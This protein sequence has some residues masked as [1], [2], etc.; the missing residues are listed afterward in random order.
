M[1]VVERSA[2]TYEPADRFVPSAAPVLLGGVP[3]IARLLVEQL[4]RD[5]AAGLRTGVFASGYPGSPLGGVDLALASA[6]GLADRPEFAL[7]PGVN[8]ELAATAVW[9]SQLPLPGRAST[10]DGTVGV[11]Y[12]KAPGVDRS[13][14][15]FRGANLFGANP[16]GGVLVLAGDDPGAK[17]STIPSASEATLASFGLPVLAPRSSE[18]IVRL[19]LLGIALSRVSGCWISLKIVTDVADGAWSVA[20][21]FR[22]LEIAIPELEW[23]GRPWTYRQQTVPGPPVAAVAE[24]ELVGPRWEMVQAFARANRLDEV[25]IDARDAWLGIVAPGKTSNDVL[26]AL[27]DLGLDAETA[28]RRGI[29]L[30]RIG[31][32]NPLERETV[33]DFARGVETVLV[34]EEKQPFL[35]TQVRDALY[36]SGA[37][38]VLGKR[39]LEGRP[40]VPADGE[41]TA[42][43]LADVLRRVLAARVELRPATAPPALT[44]PV[45]PVRRTAYFCSGCPHNRSTVVPEGSLAGGGIGCHGLAGMM[46]R[47]T[48]AV[49][50]L[51]HMG[52]EGAQWIGQS[53]THAGGH[54]FQNVGDGTFFHSGQLAVQAC[55]AAGVDV[56][57]KLLY[58]STVAMTGGQDAAG[59]RSVADV[60]R[61]LEAEG[62]VR[63]IVCA[64]E[65][66]RYRDLDGRLARNAVVWSRDRLD[67]AQLELRE[68]QGVTA[69]IY[70]QQCTN[71]ARRLRK[72]GQLP[73]RTTRVLINEDICEGCG[74]CSRKSNCLSVQP[75]ETELGTK[76]RIDQTSCNTDYSCL[77]GDCPSFVTVEAGPAERPAPVPAPAPPAVPDP[78]PAERAG[79]INVFFAGIGGTGVVTVNQVLATAALLDDLHVRTLDQTGMSQKAGP[80][81]SHL[82]IGRGMVEPANR[83][84]VGQADC[85]LALDLL[86]ASEA[87][88]LSYAS[89]ERTAAFVSTSEVPTGAMVD[90]YSGGTLPPHGLLLDRIRGSVRELT[91]LD[92][93]AAAD[94]LFGHTT[95]A[96]FLL[97]G[98]AVQAGALPISPEAIERAIELNR[99]GVADNLAAFRW[100]RVAVADRA[101]FAAATARDTAP[102]RPRHPLPDSPLAGPTREAAAV[103]AAHLAA[104]GGDGLVRRYLDGVEEAWRAERA[105]TER[106]DFSHAAAVG[107]HR[108]LAVKDE[109]EV[110]RLL[111]APEFASWVDSQVPGSRRL[112]YR[113]HPPLLRAV[114]LKRKVALGQGWRPILVL[115]ARLRFLRDTIFDPF[116]WTRLR[117]L[118]RQLARDYGAL[119]SRLSASLDADGYDR[120]TA[121][122]DAVDV[123]RG[124]EAVKIANVEHYRERLAELGV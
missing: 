18:E 106:T 93:F 42:P 48:S 14:D 32:V 62:I 40:L 68:I 5:G 6:P 45:L 97:V 78:P 39:D 100:G 54:L 124:Y 80:V 50:G 19:G 81:V 20:R 21:D 3:A 55:V 51:T 118:E 90:G 61:K 34:V 27:L 37:P 107:L 109:Y 84:G 31:M 26:Q 9:G 33:R 72:R 82:R 87:R 36:G 59:A 38:T 29:R 91:D 96:H 43:R 92:S 52:G 66:K 98:A 86:T 79:T 57:F 74:D 49:T 99:A 102:L 10:F 103:R 105:V 88:S 30:L 28:A 111:T 17:S 47:P 67:E 113:L 46:Q 112:R 12:G 101:S 4:E 122:A 56:T 83:V 41:L 85:Y 25:A 64:E 110:A 16:R 22:D 23:N 11:W 13:G 119:V 63:T 58:N 15:P 115:L 76:R 53:F 24:Q 94:A 121:A 7:V 65:P 120:A 123:V 73:A 44:L 104:Y 77:E 95:P 69:L 2:W 8:E 75:L 89:P 71:Q 1:T 35:E 60:T 114:G 108:V 117:R 116:G 70:D